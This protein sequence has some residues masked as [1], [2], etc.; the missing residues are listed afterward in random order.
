[1]GLTEY[2]KNTDSNVGMNTKPEN[3]LVMYSASQDKENVRSMAEMAT[4][5]KRQS[6]KI[7]VGLTLKF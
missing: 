7:N 3:V 6:L 1:M 4:S 5:V 2:F